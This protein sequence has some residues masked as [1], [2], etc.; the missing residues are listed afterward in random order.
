[1]QKNMHKSAK[2]TQYAIF[3]S[4]LLDYKFSMG[5]TLK[6][7]SVTE[8]RVIFLGLIPDFGHFWGEA[9]NLWPKIHPIHPRSMRLNWI[10]NG[11]LGDTL[12]EQIWPAQI[13][14]LGAPYEFLKK[15]FL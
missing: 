9:V 14:Y 2:Y 4:A 3:W 8:V 15:L 11:P 5:P 7:I 12:L 13:L 10:L 1:M 6:K